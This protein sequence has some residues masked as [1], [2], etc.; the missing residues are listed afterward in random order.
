MFGIQQA[1]E[2]LEEAGYMIL[3]NVFRPE[4][5]ERFRHG[6]IQAQGRMPSTRENPSSR[7]FAGFHRCVELAGLHADLVESAAIA[8]ALEMVYGDRDFNAIGLSDITINRSQQWHTDLLR[9]PY[10]RFGVSEVCWQAS[11]PSCYKALLYLQDGERLFVLPGSHKLGRHTEDAEAEQLA[12]SK[13]PSKVAVKSGDVVLM[14]IRLIH[15]GANQEEIN[16][17][18][19]SG[20]LKILISSVFGADDSEMTR[21]LKAGNQQRLRDWD[22]RWKPLIL[23]A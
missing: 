21:R 11:E 20:E 10:K 5:I 2:Q 1:K 16:A 14:D 15:R 4:E 17:V 23:G 3:P 18:E 19:K 6:V 7:H 12:L 22:Q 9:G 8:A 13:A